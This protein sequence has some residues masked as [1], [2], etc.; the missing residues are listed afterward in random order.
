MK[1]RDEQLKAIETI[2]K[3]LAI[4]AGA[5]TGKTEVLTRRYVNLL[6]NG[7]FGDRGEVNSVVAITFTKKAAS[8]MKQRV[9]ELVENS[10]DEK[11]LELSGDLNDPNIS[12]IDSFCGKIVK[13]NSYFLDIDQ[14]FTIMEERDSFNLFN[15]ISAIS[16]DIFSCP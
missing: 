2:D 3:N 15:I 5:G 16:A 10:K 4:N 14:S 9:R 13:E 8:E 1:L 6:K 11:L 7:D 12:T